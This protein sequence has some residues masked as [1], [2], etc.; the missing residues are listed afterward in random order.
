MHWLERRWHSPSRFF[1]F[2]VSLIFGLVVRVRRACYRLGLLE[3]TRLQVP[4]LI[5]G[6]I[7]AGGSGKTPLVA[8]LAQ[9]LASRGLHPGIISRGYGGNAVSPLP[10]DQSSDPERVGDEPVLLARTGFPVWV[11]RN[12][13]DAARGLLSA[14]PQCDILIGD[15]GLQ[16]Y[17]LYRDFEIVVIDGARGFGN[18]NL[19]PAGPLREPVSRLDNADAIVV[20]STGQ[21]LPLNSPTPTFAMH[22]SGQTFVN[23]G[24][25]EI[26]T[27][28]FAGKK[29]HAIAGIG[30]PQRFFDHLTSLGLEFTPHPFPDHHP[31]RAEDLEFEAC[32]I[33]LMTE[34]DA[35]KCKAFNLEKCWFLPVR[36]E[37][38]PALLELIMKAL[39]K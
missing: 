9:A 29:L 11:G 13:A 35:I 18:G 39:R 36:T 12:R 32:D 26:T 24:H 5:V 7:T 19:L 31:Y 15:D 27:S 4:V 22:L 37:V 16:H 34:K 38:D 20:N 3:S 6:N 21:D 30:N 23:L 1:L 8:A 14:N 25:P 28:G 2:P 10:V 17:A 33:I